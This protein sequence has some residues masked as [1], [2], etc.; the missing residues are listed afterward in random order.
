MREFF[1]FVEILFNLLYGTFPEIVLHFSG[2]SRGGARLDPPRKAGRAGDKKP[3]PTRSSRSGSA[4][5]T[6]VQSTSKFHFVKVI[7]SGGLEIPNFAV[8]EWTLP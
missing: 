5:A 3:P 1:L 6:T 8:T 2:R 4:T 7:T